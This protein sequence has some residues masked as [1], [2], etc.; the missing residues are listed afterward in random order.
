MTATHGEDQVRSYGCTYGCGNPYDVILI[1]VQD[2]T[3]EFLCMP[4]FLKL[5]MQLIQAMTEPGSAHVL[6]ALAYAASNPLATT[7]GP[8]GKRRGHNAPA[9][10]DDPSIVEAFDSVITVDELPDEFKQ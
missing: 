6:A 5:A 8:S 1:N 2:G 10:T 7:P 4:D 9:T 3:T